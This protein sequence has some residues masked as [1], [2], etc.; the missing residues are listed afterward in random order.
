M[1][2]AIRVANKAGHVVGIVKKSAKTFLRAARSSGDAS[3]V[4][5]RSQSSGFDLRFTDARSDETQ[6]RR[7]KTSP[8]KKPLARLRLGNR[9]RAAF[10]RETEMDEILKNWYSLV[11]PIC[12]LCGAIFAALIV[13]RLLFG[14]VDSWTRRRSGL[15]LKS[16]VRH[17]R[18]PFA[19]LLPFLTLL[20]ALPAAHLSAVALVPIQRAVGLGLIAAVGWF[21]IVCSAVIFDVVSAHYR[22]DV[23]D[24]VEARRVQT[25]AQVLHRIV[26][27]IVSIVTLSVMLMT[28][29]QIKHIGISLLAS[30]GLAGLVI[31]TAMKS[32]L[33][34]LIAGVQIAFT[35]PIRIE[36]AVVVEGE[37]GWIEEIG[38]TYVTV[39]LWDLRR[40]VLP[41]SYFL[42]HPFQNWTRQSA[43]LLGSVFL[44]VDYTVP[45]EEV[46]KELRRIVENNPKWRGQ[47]CVLQVTDATTNAIQLRALVDARDS[48]S[49]WDLRC[50]VR[51]ALI[52]FLQ[53]K[54]PQGL[55]RVRTEF[56]AVPHGNGGAPA[57]FL[58]GAAHPHQS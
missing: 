21:A 57:Q 35:Q 46:R 40:M 1:P 5:S 39:R 56:Q 3:G 27:V 7:N 13:H 22:M 31:G 2:A 58:T 17:G 30:A 23:P 37:W 14:V 45:V 16:V 10:F 18:R 6:L 41:L 12:L 25:Q 42:E 8:P 54:Y 4:K 38:T 20:A 53:E 36:D 34:S 11:W 43:D 28:F 51:E 15:L 32:S 44:Y 24:N 49:A 29:P 47:V 50:E 52:Q 55:P 19:W 9:M 26:I 48:S 33:S